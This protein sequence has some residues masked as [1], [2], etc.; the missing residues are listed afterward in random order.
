MHLQV[1]VQASGFG[2]SHLDCVQEDGN[3]TERPVPN[4]MERAS[5]PWK[6][7][8]TSADYIAVRL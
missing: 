1:D 6:L 2:H 5:D 7:I 8:K 4:T 3:V